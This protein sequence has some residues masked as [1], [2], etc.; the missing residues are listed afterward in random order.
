MLGQHIIQSRYVKWK[1]VVEIMHVI[2]ML[3]DEI[4]QTTSTVVTSQTH[5]NTTNVFY[6][7]YACNIMMN[8]I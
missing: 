8:A 7:D 4:G 3:G 6:D 5:K 1:D 2:Q